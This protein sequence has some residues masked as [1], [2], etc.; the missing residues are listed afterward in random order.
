MH[1]HTS[2]EI[3]IDGNDDDVKAI[4]DVIKNIITDED[5]D[6]GCVIESANKKSSSF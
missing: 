4:N 5:F 3:R 6:E 1:G 2:F